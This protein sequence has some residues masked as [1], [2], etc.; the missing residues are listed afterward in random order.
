MS[1]IL[2][3]S[4]LHAYRH[5]NKTSRQEDCVNCLKW[6]CEIAKKYNVSDIIFLGDL[7]H[8]KIKIHTLVYNQIYEIIES[9][10][11]FNW[12]LL[13]GNHDMWFMNDT[14]VNSI[15]P[16]R[17]IK[18]VN[19]I[20]KPSTY[21]IS[22]IYI[23]FIPYTKDP[24]S[25]IVQ[26]NKNSDIMCGHLAING[27]MLNSKKSKSEVE[28]ETDSDMIKVDPYL[29]K[30]WNQVFLG[31]YHGSQILDGFIEYIG[32]PLQLSWGEAEQDKHVIILNTKT[33]EK[34]YIL[35]DFSPRHVYIE[36]DNIDKDLNNCFVKVKTDVNKADIVKIKDEIKQKFNILD[37]DF[38]EDKQ[39]EKKDDSIIEKF[40]LATGDILEKY[41]N[42]VEN[43][44]LDKDLLLSIGKKII[45]Q[46]SL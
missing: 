1:N 43:N 23:D 29:F 10:S 8:D 20:A 37:I 33:K 45:N 9:N 25:S 11:N 12:F 7:F 18:N 5:K 19:I 2:L 32:S 36:S 22:G 24:I 16:F 35:N 34:K 31:H 21:S 41:I 26:F 46:E 38:I 17:S 15:K 6:I 44:E 3:F 27:A 40:N 39:E 42:S 4:D 28:V 30:K 13:V 14:S